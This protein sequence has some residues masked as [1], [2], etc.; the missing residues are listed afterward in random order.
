MVGRKTNKQRREQQAVTAREKAAIA[1]AAHQRAAQRR[2]AMTVLSTITVLAVAG[3]IVAAIAIHSTSGNKNDRSAAAAGVVDTVTSVSPAALQTVGKGTA[4]LLPK[5]TNG[6]PPL[7]LHGK[8]EFL[9]IGGEFCPLCAAERWSMIQALSRFGTFKNLTQIRSATDDGDL[10]TFSF[11]KSSYTSKYLS[12]VPV[13]NEDRNS[14]QLQPLTASQTKLFSKYTTGFP[15]LYFG[16]K[17]VQTSVGYNP[18]DLTGLNWQQIATQ[19]KTP[20]SKLAQDILGEANNLTATLC[21]ITNNLPASA[22]L[23]PTV[24][25]LQSELGA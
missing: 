11:Y 16:G 6:D 9:F 3:V 19:L 17:Y 8:P 14:K 20:T 2:R 15:F 21:K 1:R 13:E 25:D 22:C 24:T 10:A 18:D 12:F 23:T 4:N 5:P 7:T